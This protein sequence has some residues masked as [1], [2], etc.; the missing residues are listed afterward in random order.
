MIP[1]RGVASSFGARA[2]ASKV[3]RPAASDPAGGFEVSRPCVDCPPATS[4]CASPANERTGRMTGVRRVRTDVANS[5]LTAR[6]FGSYS[7]D[8]RVEQG[9]PAPQI[10]RRY[11]PGRARRRRTCASWFGSWGLHHT[12]DLHPAQY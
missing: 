3:S 10:R 9:G 7:E 1:P 5:F 12:E 6:G 4:V 2:E 8:S 11:G